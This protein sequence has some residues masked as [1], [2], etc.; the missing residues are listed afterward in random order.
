MS[1]NEKL[2]TGAMIL[3]LAGSVASC[4][5]YVPIKEAHHLGNMR[6]VATKVCRKYALD[7]QVDK[8]FICMQPVV[9]H[10]QRFQER[11]DSPAIDPEENFYPAYEASL[12]GIMT[13]G[14]ELNLYMKTITGCMLQL[15]DENIWKRSKEDA[16]IEHL[17]NSLSDVCRAQMFKGI[18]RINSYLEDTRE[19]A[20]TAE[21]HI[22]QYMRK[23]KVRPM[24]KK[25][26]IKKRRTANKLAC[27]AE[28]MRLTFATNPT[29]PVKIRRE[30]RRFMQAEKY[31][32]QLKDYKQYADKLEG[33]RKIMRKFKG[34]RR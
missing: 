20:K 14:A 26:L 31:T 15:S 23:K 11:F 5:I 34:R 25:D 4:G 7:G 33:F 22:N 30:M 2:A 3:G 21:Q 10:Y 19:L 12:Y 6:Q 9:E 18:Q 28:T 8:A 13:T 1:I 16:N 29:D 24:L 17:M 27:R 32:C